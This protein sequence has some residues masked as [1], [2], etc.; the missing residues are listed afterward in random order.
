MKKFSLSMIVCFAAASLSAQAAS[1]ASFIK[2]HKGNSDYEAYAVL[3]ATQETH[4]SSEIEAH[5]KKIDFLPGQH[6][7]KDD[8]LMEFDC[9]ALD[10]QVQRLVSITKAT[11][12]KYNS[13]LELKKM[14]S[15]SELEVQNAATENEKAQA[16]VALAQLKQS[17]CKLTAPYDGDV[18]AKLANEGELVK[19]DEPLLEIISNQNLEVQMY[20]PSKWL[21]AVQPGTTFTLSLSELGA[22]TLLM[23]SVTKIVG[24]V[25]AAS[26]SVLVYGQLTLPETAAP[27]LFAGMSGTASFDINNSPS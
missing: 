12:A 5:I 10:I 15:I 26:Q 19:L 1:E 2:Q 11:Q 21:S 25:D 13:S 7:K 14:S 20:I 27:K 24:K 23:G 9:E 16:D 6:F 18:V 4:V 17:K 8:L 22:T 3:T